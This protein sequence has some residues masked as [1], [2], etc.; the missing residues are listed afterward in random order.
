MDGKQLSFRPRRLGLVF[1]G[2]WAARAQARYTREC[3][4][5]NQKLSPQSSQGAVSE[6]VSELPLGTSLALDVSQSL[7]GVTKG[8]AP[9]GH[10]LPL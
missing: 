1:L 10:V 2:L 8:L 9:G 6:P 3:L 5:A 7:T 4:K